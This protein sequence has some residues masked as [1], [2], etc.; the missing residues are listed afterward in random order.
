[1]K[2]LLTLSL[3][4]LSFFCKAQERKT[5]A[6]SYGTG[7]GYFGTLQKSGYRS[8]EGTYLGIIGFNYSLE[9][10]KNFF[11][12]SGV[13]YIKYNYIRTFSN[14]SMLPANR[15]LNMISVPFKFRFEAGNYIFFNGGI[16]ADVEVGKGSNLRGI[17]AGLGFGL[18]MRVAKK[19]SIFVNPQ[20][21]IHNLISFLSSQ[22]LAELNVAFGLAYQIK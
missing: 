13:Q 1:M 10:G 7:G 11:F 8:N 19:I 5:I 4:L 20:T 12:E 21:N 3:L 14:P 22:K 17:G 6:F 16:M 9:T 2:K 15:S 18:Q